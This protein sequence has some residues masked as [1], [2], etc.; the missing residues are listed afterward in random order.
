MNISKSVVLNT[1]SYKLGMY[2][3]YPPKTEYVFSYGESRGGKFPD[4]TMFG[5]QIF[6]KDVLSK[7]V[8]EAEVAMAKS[9]AAAHGTPFNYDGWMR[10]VKKCDGY[11][12]LEIKAVPEGT[13]VPTGNALFTIQNTDPEFFWLTSYVETALLRAVWYGTTVATNSRAI[14]KVLAESMERTGADINTLP[15]KLV[16]FGARGVSSFESAG[17]GGAAHLINF[18]VTDTITG[19]LTAMEYYSPAASL[20]AWVTQGDDYFANNMP[21]FSIPA[22]EH[23]TMTSWGGREGELAAMRNMLTQFAKPGVTL[24][25]VSDSYDIY[26]ATKNFWGT[27]LK[28]E[29][30]D[31]GATV[32][33]RPDSG[34]PATVV[35]DILNILDEQF[36]TTKNTKGYKV[37]PDY[38]RV[39]QGDGIT[40]DSI[41]GIVKAVEDAGFSADN[42]AYGMGGG[43]LQIMDRDTL[44]FAMKASAAYVNGKWIDV[45]KDPV[46]DT[47][48]KSKKGQLTLVT[49]DYGNFRTVRKSEVGDQVEVLKT[50]FLNGIIT[51]EY[52]FDEVRANAAL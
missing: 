31:S 8:T 30:I 41:V 25:C 33:I 12:P 4:T 51:K 13:T 37:L 9:F 52:T 48:K 7:Q 6:L 50:V 36:G 43:M 46:T 17:I 20:A 26:N 10:I 23:S 2:L 38:I 22:S 15:F 34:D 3:M 29:V 21:G 40:Y 49:D 27:A 42:V 45:F 1:D 47:V 35:V 32:V 28:Q 19:A 5:L 18:M 16:D 14:K 11:L 44:K 24:A 39:I